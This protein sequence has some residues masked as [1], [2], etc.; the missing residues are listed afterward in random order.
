MLYEYRHDTLAKNA[1]G[2]ESFLY[3]LIPA[4]FVRSVAFAIDPT[5]RFKVSPV[6]I[7]PPN[8]TRYRQTASLLQI[9]TRTYS[10][11]KTTWSQE[12]NYKGI[13]ICSS[14]Y[15]VYH[16]VDMASTTVTLAPQPAL[17]D[18]IKD[19]T[20]RTR[21]YGSYQGELELFKSQL[22]SPSRTTHWPRIERKF[23]VGAPA[24]STCRAAGGVPDY[25]TGTAEGQKYF[26]SSGA[27]LSLS[28]YNALTASE[29]AFNKAL[30]QK[31]AISM[32]K[33]IGPYSRD[34]SLTRNIVELRDLPRSVLSLKNTM[35]DLRKVFNTFA[36][37]RSTRD[38]IFDLRKTSKNIPSEYLSYHFG[39]RQTYKDLVDLL[40]LPQK[41]S[42]RISFL[43]QRSGKPTTLRSK[44]IHLSA[45]TGVSGFTYDSVSN[46]EWFQTT[47]SRIVRESEIRLV[48][49]S[50]FDFPPI[51]EPILRSKFF[52]EKI[53][54]TPRF[55]D[56]YNITPWT[57]LFDWFTGLG[58]YL[59]LIE[60]INHDPSLINWG[61]V[62]VKTS[63]QLISDY[64]SVVPSFT[65]IYQD[66]VLVSSSHINV[67]NTHS[68]RLIYECQTRQDIASIL[69][70]KRTSVP[71]S[72]SAYQY[73]ILGALLA[74]RTDH[75]RPGF[76]PRS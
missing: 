63:G 44:R 18:I 59:E 55:I 75:T 22:I 4:S 38:L 29:I 17:P 12:S 40:D 30:A 67:P 71:S 48:V 8:R 26:Y 53:G 54:V 25:E 76:A 42:K 10:P 1:R 20:S 5:Y 70:V 56:V 35:E 14:P 51:N 21:L 49:S 52:Y 31:Y 6:T 43:I 61:M 60:E 39:W 47:V 32:L 65:D 23:T 33:G 46:H 73:S 62:T 2:L 58:N 74:Q 27:S 3:R 11:Y 66:N 69:D 16:P 13:A 64:T 68:S 24:D 72:L 45:E 9:R 50:T 41:L 28:T 34:Y 37:S 7:T 57:W 19:T 15:L 36:S